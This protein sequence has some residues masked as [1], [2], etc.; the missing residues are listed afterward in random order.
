MIKMVAA[1]LNN[2]TPDTSNDSTASDIV[3]VLYSSYDTIGAPLL[4]RLT[5]ELYKLEK[6]K[7]PR[8]RKLISNI[9]TL[10]TKLTELMI[11]EWC[12]SKGKSRFNDSVQAHISPYTPLK[13]HQFYAMKCFFKNNNSFCDLTCDIQKDWELETIAGCGIISYFK[14][15]KSFSFNN[16]NYAEF[17]ASTFIFSTLRSKTWRNFND[18]FTYFT[19]FMVKREFGMIRSMIE[20]GLDEEKNQIQME[21]DEIENFKKQL[22]KKHKN[23]SVIF[24]NI[25]LQKHPKTLKFFIK[26]LENDKRIKQILLCRP[27]Q[28]TDGSF[29]YSILLNSIHNSIG[30]TECF[31]ILLQFLSKIMKEREFENLLDMHK[32]SASILFTTLD[33]K[34]DAKIISIILSTLNAK[35]GKERVKEFI[36]SRDY[37]GKTIFDA[38]CSES[39]FEIRNSRIHWFSEVI[40]EKL[41]VLFIETRKYLNKKELLKLISSTENYNK[42]NIIHKCVMRSDIHVLKFIWNKISEL[43]NGNVQSLKAMITATSNYHNIRNRNALQLSTYNPIVAFPTDFLRFF[44][45]IFGKQE[46]FELIKV[47]DDDENK[48]IHNLIY[49]KNKHSIEL[50]FD[51]LEKIFSKEQFKE[52]LMLKGFG[53]KNILSK[54]LEKPILEKQEVYDY[55]LSLVYANFDVPREWKII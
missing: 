24:Y 9:Y 53:E 13:A 30:K 39:T 8:K 41:E 14:A 44:N 54:S 32:K 55:L 45:E 29:K 15:K 6:S 36:K 27:S 4:L 21:N 52:I 22:K 49:Y 34:V 7:N 20:N 25:S 33:E 5:A 28:I 50:V 23:I 35:C 17:F 47:D 31:E 51:E 42:T 19:D 43:L 1:Y 12:G 37:V 46:L 26:L 48:F 11:S 3:N 16:Q 10:F 38:F 40:K 2:S 18:F